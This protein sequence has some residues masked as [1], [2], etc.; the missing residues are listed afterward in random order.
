[1]RVAPVRAWETGGNERDGW[2]AI[3]PFPGVWGR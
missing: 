3:T 2:V 1:M